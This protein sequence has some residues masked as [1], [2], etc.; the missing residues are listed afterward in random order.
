MH[1]NDARDI[2]Q[3]ATHRNDAPRDIAQTATQRLP[4]THGLTDL[5]CG[6]PCILAVVAVFAIGATVLA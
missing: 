3:T 2:A 1:R 4:T 5:T 6:Q